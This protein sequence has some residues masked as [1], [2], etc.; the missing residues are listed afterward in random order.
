[1][2]KRT[3]IFYGWYL[4]GLTI[5]TMMLVYGIRNSF[6]VLLGPILTDFGWYRG[7]TAVMLSLNILVYGFTA[8]VAGSLVDRWK[9]RKVAMI[10]IGVLAVATASC[11]LATELW[12]FYLLFGVL[13]PIGSAFCGLP[14]LNPAL[15]NWFGRGRGLA[16]GLGQIGGG[17]S[18][19]Y[20]MVVNA[21]ISG[22]GWSGAYIFMAGMLLV[23]LLPLYYLI[24]HYRPG[25][26]GM[27]SYRAGETPP[28]VLPPGVNRGVS[29]WTLRGAL[30]TR[31]LWLLVFSQMLYWGIGNYVVLAHQIKF[32][33]DVGY[34]SV[35][36]AFVFAMF[37]IVSI[38]GQICAFISDRIGREWTITIACI[39]AAGGMV[40]LISVRDNSNI[41]L[42]YFYAVS[43]GIGTGLFSPT[44]FVG[45]ADIFYGKNIGAISAVILTG[46]GVGGA[47][48]PWLG[49][50]IY[51]V[52]GSYHSAFI[53]CL[54]AYILAGI[55]FWMAAPRHAARIRAR[56]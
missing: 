16:I 10:G 49:G 4:V 51:D 28:T 7:S 14:I 35:M 1:M 37:G 36:A 17:L 32:A 25:D 55:S 52:T 46:S 29:D 48:G 31:N 3:P 21:V 19:A 34:S 38:G 47:I 40:A 13:V 27:L 12:H 56:F 5:V 23:L 43:S 54:V 33:V 45:T 6:S 2:A 22:F 53:I 41:W 8:P 39:L 30:R 15:M 20:G 50:Y 44:I 24:F 11:S 42:L 18:F 26:K 9:P